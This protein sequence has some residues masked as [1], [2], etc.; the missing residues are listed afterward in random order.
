MYKGKVYREKEKAPVRITRVAKQPM[1]R[2]VQ[3]VYK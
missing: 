2:K 3:V 1:K